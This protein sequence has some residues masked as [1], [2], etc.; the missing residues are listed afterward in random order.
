MNKKAIVL[1]PWTVWL[2]GREEPEDFD[3][4]IQ[5]R[6]TRDSVAYNDKSNAF[7]E[8]RDKYFD[9]GYVEVLHPRQYPEFEMIVDEDGEPK[10]LPVNGIASKIYGDIIVGPAVLLPKGTIK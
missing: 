4:E 1:A 6:F 8:M 3:S 9:G 10:Q 7:V 2:P 5:N